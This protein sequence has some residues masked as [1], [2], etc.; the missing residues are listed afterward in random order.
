MP[1]HGGSASPAGGAGHAGA[2]DRRRGRASWRGGATPK[3]WSRLGR[4]R[5]RHEPA[6]HRR[7]DLR[8][9]IYGSA[10]EPSD[11]V[12]PEPTRARASGG[13]RARR[14][15]MGATKLVQRQQ[16]LR[17]AARRR[18]AARARRRDR[19]GRAPRLRSTIGL[20]RAVGC[21]R[22][23]VSLP[24]HT[25]AAYG[26]RTHSSR[27]QRSVRRLVSSI[28]TPPPRPLRRTPLAAALTRR[29]RRG[30][31]PATPARRR[32]TTPT[33]RVP[34]FCRRADDLAHI[35]PPAA[36]CRPPPARACCATRRPSM[37][38]D[39]ASR[40]PERGVAASRLRARRRR[41]SCRR[42]RA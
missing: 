37:R 6:V 14:G 18:P 17:A 35:A 33:A 1:W 39:D 13:K 11:D 24:R 40:A 27:L 16:V 30:P 4:S 3:G 38:H 41:H 5:A 42:R 25:P 20:E 32:R 10:V 31:R 26:A 9:P 21:S 15:L 29:S 19:R 28:T 23:A 8:E 2:G 22:G 7:S 12:E 34:Q 36:C